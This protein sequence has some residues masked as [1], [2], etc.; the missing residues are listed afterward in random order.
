[1]FQSLHDHHQAYLQIQLIDAGYMLGSQLCL[2]FIQASQAKCVNKYKNLRI[3]VL[4]CCANIYFNRQ[5]LKQNLNP[6]YSKYFII[7][8]LNFNKPVCLQSNS[9]HWPLSLY[10]QGK[11]QRCLPDGG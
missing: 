2:T 3:K 1:M 9:C 4:K 10:S 8:V 5:C 6:K 7:L 11:R